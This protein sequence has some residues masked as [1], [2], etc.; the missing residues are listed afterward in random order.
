MSIDELRNDAE[1]AKV[2]PLVWRKLQPYILKKQQDFAKQN[3]GKHE[4]IGRFVEFTSELFTDLESIQSAIDTPKD[5]KP[6][7]PRL[8]N[9]VLR[10]VSSAPKA[11]PI[12]PT[13]HASKSQPTAT[14]EASRPGVPTA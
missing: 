4:E 12:A 5:T 9:D 7:R 1:F 3:K 10:P 2:W 14:S 6:A 11:E 13:P 8:S